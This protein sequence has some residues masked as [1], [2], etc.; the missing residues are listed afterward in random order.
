[1]SF[2]DFGDVI[3]GNAL[4][5]SCSGASRTSGHLVSSPPMA[6]VMRKTSAAFLGETHIDSEAFS[7]G[8]F[9]QYYVADTV[10]IGLSGGMVFRDINDKTFEFL[11]E[12][13]AEGWFV[14]AAFKVYVDPQF[15]LISER[16]I[17]REQH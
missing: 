8:L 13:G 6:L 14:D 3:E 5:S 10:T 11:E 1:M 17:R 4:A 15:A 2:G 9:G 12:Y 16:R 7:A